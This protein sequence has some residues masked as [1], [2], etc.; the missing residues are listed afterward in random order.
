MVEI[1]QF[2]NKIQSYKYSVLNKLDSK[3]CTNF[4]FD[5]KLWEENVCTN[6]NL[7]NI[8]LIPS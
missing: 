5:C 8:L 1:V 4:Q 3:N 6:A 2:F 7:R